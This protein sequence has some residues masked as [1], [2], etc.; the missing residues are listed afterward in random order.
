MLSP[1][2]APLCLPVADAAAQRAAHTAHPVA[3]VGPAGRLRWRRE[4]MGSRPV[5]L[6]AVALIGLLMAGPAAA[7]APAPD[8]RAPASAPGLRHNEALPGGDR[9]AQQGQRNKAAKRN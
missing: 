2:F 9:L 1:A 8:A 4:R 6:S 3:D 7:H 5:Y